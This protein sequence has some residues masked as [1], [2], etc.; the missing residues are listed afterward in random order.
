MAGQNVFTVLPLGSCEGAAWFTISFFTA[1]IR[2]LGSSAAQ[3]LFYLLGLYGLAAGHA[4]DRSLQ[5]SGAQEPGP[6]T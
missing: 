4:I 5:K 2:N 6:V 3:M 1:E